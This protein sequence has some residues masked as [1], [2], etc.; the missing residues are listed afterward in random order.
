MWNHP[1]NPIF[2]LLLTIRQH[3]WNYGSFF[4]KNVDIIENNMNGGMVRESPPYDFWIIFNATL[5]GMSHRIRIS[6]YFWPRDKIDGIMAIFFIIKNYFPQ[7][8]QKFFSKFF[9]V[10]LEISVIFLKTLEIFLKILPS[11]SRNFRKWFSRFFEIIFR[12]LRSFF[13]NF[14][15][16]SRNPPNFSKIL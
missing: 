2:H 10:I 7:N 14:R 6:T 4:K 16:I 13:E 8:F 5:S 12:V 9:K 3:W 15:I 11:F 1:L